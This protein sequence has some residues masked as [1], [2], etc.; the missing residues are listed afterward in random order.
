MIKILHTG[1]IHLGDLEVHKGCDFLVEQQGHQPFE[2]RGGSVGK[3]TRGL[4]CPKIQ[5]IGGAWSIFRLT[6]RI[7]G[8][9]G[10]QPERIFP[11]AGGHVI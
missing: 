9:E 10:R 6:G 4:P 11:E 2:R 5:G 3:E 1:D 8:L 7:Y